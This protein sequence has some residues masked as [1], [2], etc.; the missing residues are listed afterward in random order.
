MILRVRSVDRLRTT[1]ESRLS[2][3]KTTSTL[4]DPVQRRKLPGLRLFR[5]SLLKKYLR[6]EIWE[7]SMLELDALWS[8]LALF[9]LG[10]MLRD[11]S[12][13]DQLGLMACKP[14]PGAF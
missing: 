8:L 1:E 3:V 12:G 14:P 10:V 9:E 11:E 6:L 13:N 4:R 5:L 7:S 2:L